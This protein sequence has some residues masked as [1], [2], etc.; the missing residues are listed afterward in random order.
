MLHH[1]DL[2]PEERSWFSPVPATSASRTLN[3][4]A[5]IGL[6]PE[7]LRQAAQRSLR[8]GLVTRSELANVEAALAPFGG[9][10]E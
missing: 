9:L 6:S 5:N 8:R 2:A 1:A 3:D 7:L 4:C 10:A